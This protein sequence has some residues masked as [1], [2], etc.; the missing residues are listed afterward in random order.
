MT[1]RAFRRF[2]LLISLSLLVAVSGEPR[3]ASLILAGI[4][5]ATAVFDAV[6]SITNPED[7]DDR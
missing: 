2:L 1:R 3:G 4:G 6:R 7:T 5:A